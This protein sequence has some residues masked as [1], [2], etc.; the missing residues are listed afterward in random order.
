MRFPTG[1]VSS[2][3]KFGFD[4]NCPRADALRGAILGLRSYLVEGLAGSP[5]VPRTLEANLLTEGVPYR[6]GPVFGAGAVVD[7]R[8]AGVSWSLRTGE[9]GR[10]NDILD[11]LPAG[12]G[13]LPGPT[14]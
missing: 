3:L 8:G 4:P 14:D 7:G 12:L 10:G 5:A 1:V 9:S 2:S 11:L 13:A 6:G